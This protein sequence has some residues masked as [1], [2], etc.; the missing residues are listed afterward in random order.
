MK[1]IDGLR[2]AGVVAA[3]VAG[4]VAGSAPAPALA[5]DSSPRLGWGGLQGAWTTKVS[6]LVACGNPGN[7]RRTFDAL[8]NFHAGGTSSETG[9]GVPPS[10]RSPSVG[11]WYRIGRRSYYSSFVF[12]RFDAAGV[13][14]GSQEIT[15]VIRLAPDGMSYDADSSVTLK[16]TSGNVLGP[17]TCA[18]EKGTRF[19]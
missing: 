6:I 18:V 12:L 14:L 1:T 11:T 3:L 17:P 5:A 7:V 4:L 9:A 19:G 8:N 15:R 10:L 13:H 2:S 16:D